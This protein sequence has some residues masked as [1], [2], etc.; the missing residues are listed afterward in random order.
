MVEKI[1]RNL[2]NKARKSIYEKDTV[3]YKL[4]NE[5]E[6]RDIIFDEEDEEMPFRALF[7]EQK[8]DIDRSSTLYSIKGPFELL[9]ADIAN[10]KFLSK[11][12]VDPHYCLLYADLLPSKI[13]TYPMKKISLLAKKWSNFMKKLKQKVIVKNK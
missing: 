2:L 10:I 5:I 1:N 11:S 9:H 6:N 13:Y 7:I 12:A 3:F 8:K 4:Y